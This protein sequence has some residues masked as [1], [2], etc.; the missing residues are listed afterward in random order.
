[1]PTNKH[2][3][4]SMYC[5]RRSIRFIA[6]LSRDQHHSRHSKRC[7]AYSYPRDRFMEDKCREHNG[8][9]GGCL[10]EYG[11]DGGLRVLHSTQPE[12]HLQVSGN[13][14]SEYSEPLVWSQVRYGL[15][16][17]ASQERTKTEHSH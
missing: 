14:A 16:E 9:N 6:L 5:S 15:T 1:M 10:I 7:R 17:L 12:N 13:G 11:R 4:A 8:E 2:E 3:I